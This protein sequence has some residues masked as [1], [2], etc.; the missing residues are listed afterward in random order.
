MGTER[1]IEQ[2]E[3]KEVELIPAEIAP[4]FVYAIAGFMTALCILSYKGA[5]LLSLQQEKALAY[6]ANAVY[7]T[8]M[9]GK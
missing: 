5:V 7:T 6:I 8:I 3:G 1:S 4:M 9:G 2:R